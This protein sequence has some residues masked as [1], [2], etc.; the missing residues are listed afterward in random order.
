[1]GAGKTLCSVD[2]ELVLPCGDGPCGEGRVFGGEADVEAADGEVW[3]LDVEEV[4]VAYGT[5]F[6]DWNADVAYDDGISKPFF[7]LTSIE[8]VL[9]IVTHCLSIG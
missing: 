8:G 6:K 5:V 4:G 1:M 9:E 3:V 2:D 7:Q